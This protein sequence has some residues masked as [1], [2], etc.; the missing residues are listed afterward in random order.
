MTGAPEQF[1]RTSPKTSDTAP[2]RKGWVAPAMATASDIHPSDPGAFVH[3]RRGK[4]PAMFLLAHLL[5]GTVLGFP[6]TLL[7][8]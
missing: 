1:P 8:G 7:A 6:V 2:G 4:T 5:Y 3:H